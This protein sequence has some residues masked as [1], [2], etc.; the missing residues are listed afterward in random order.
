[1]KKKRKLPQY[2][3]AYT[4]MDELL[5]SPT[6]PLQAE[7]RTYQLTRMYKARTQRRRIGGLFPML[8]TCWKP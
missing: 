8:S 6:A 2:E 3:C 5:A 7:K 1:M 4:V